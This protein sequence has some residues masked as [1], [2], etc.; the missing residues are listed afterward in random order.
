MGSNTG[1]AISH[2]ETDNN[3]FLRFI[4]QLRANQDVPVGRKL[5]SVVHEV[6]QHLTEPRG[7][8]RN[9]EL[10]Q[11]RIYFGAYFQPFSTRFSREERNATFDKRCKRHAAFYKLKS[12]RL[13][14]REIEN[15]VDDR[16]KCLAG[17]PDDRQIA[18]V[19]PI[20]ILTART[21]LV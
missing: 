5:D 1:T 21:R 14:R 3:R 7:I 9:S 19:L 11:S 18:C 8:G 15:I 13:Q 10:I 12:T 4:E 20:E 17:V 2:K 6:Q 16:E